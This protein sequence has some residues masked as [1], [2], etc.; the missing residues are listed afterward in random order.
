MHNG[1]EMHT[2]VRNVRVCTVHACATVYGEYIYGCMPVFVCVL[3]CL[4]E[5]VTFC[6]HH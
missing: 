4:C 1:Y 3:I 2:L 5:R 6:R